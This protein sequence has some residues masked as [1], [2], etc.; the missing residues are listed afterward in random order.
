MR[1]SAVLLCL[2]LA[3]PAATLSAQVKD[4]QQQATAGGSAVS[5]RPGMMETWFPRIEGFTAAARVQ[6]IK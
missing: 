3:L 5:I 2:L 6:R 1:R 4:V